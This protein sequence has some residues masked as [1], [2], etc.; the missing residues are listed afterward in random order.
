MT[1]YRSSSLDLLR[2]IAISLV[3]MGH[4]YDFGSHKW[5]SILGPFGWAGVDLFFVLSGYLIANQLFQALNKNN[6]I[7]LK[8]FY[9]RRA[10]RILPPYLTVLLIY[11][12]F[13]S[14]IE[15]GTLPPYWKFLTFTQNFGLN[16]NVEGAF[17]HAWSLCV[18]EHFYLFFPLIVL[19]FHRFGNDTKA[20][21]FASSL[22]IGGFTLRY[23]LWE[24]YV[25]PHYASSDMDHMLP[26]F[27]R[28]IYYPTYNRLDGLV[29]GVCIAAIQHFK[30]NLW[31][32]LDHL[33]NWVLGAGIGLV[34]LAYYLTLDHSSLVASTFGFPVLAFGFCFLVMSAVLPS[35]YFYKVKIRGIEWSATLAF[36]F[37][38]LHKQIIF[39]AKNWLLTLGITEVSWL[40]PSTILGLSVLAS[41][42]LYLVV[43]RPSMAL[44]KRY[45]PL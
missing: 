13:P 42:I 23:F 35:G 31:E 18:E 45:L 20:F 1:G 32:R 24:K 30:T 29:L 7:S 4:F 33:A 39:H 21:V 40:F 8:K 43:E 16:F 36:T 27:Y 34:L 41:L 37:Y 38:L 19:L 22:L 9:I 11:W 26:V 3:F 2:T 44:R 15:R 17:S 10:L 28:E 5:F 25:G 14:F 6:Q 12:I